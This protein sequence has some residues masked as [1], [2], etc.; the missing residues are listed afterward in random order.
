M[1]IQTPEA[2]L[3]QVRNNL[4]PFSEIEE[5]RRKARHVV[6]YLTKNSF[7]AL[8]REL[9]DN[10][11]VPDSSKGFSLSDFEGSEVYP[12]DD[13][14]KRHKEKHTLPPLSYGISMQRPQWFNL[15]Q[16]LGFDPTQREQ[17]I[18]KEM[19]EG[20]TMALDELGVS[21]HIKRGEDFEFALVRR[22]C[23]L[24]AKTH[25]LGGAIDPRKLTKPHLAMLIF[26]YLTLADMGAHRTD[27]SCNGESLSRY[28]TNR[29]DVVSEAIPGWLGLPS[30]MARET[31]RVY[32]SLMQGTEK[33]IPEAV[34]SMY[35]LQEEIGD[36]L[37]TP[38]MFS[39]GSTPN[40]IAVNHLLSPLIGVIK[41][42]EYVASGE[43]KPE[44]IEEIIA[45][46]GYKV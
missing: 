25:Q 44:D 45:G 26:E 33:R 15:A 36:R 38:V 17:A 37:L 30:G 20:S 24:Y 8:V 7:E 4:H 10:L 21:F 46:K 2:I 6:E 14:D 16:R 27:P 19:F 28:L 35:W 29:L 12:N 9:N 5:R 42:C 43:V 18:P 32:R 34:A 41:L 3:S 40:E 39:L 1:T 31:S 13:Y 11:K 22:D 23:T